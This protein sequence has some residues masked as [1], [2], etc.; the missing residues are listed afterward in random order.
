MSK[1]FSRWEREFCRELGESIRANDW[2]PRDALSETQ[3]D[4]YLAKWIVPHP[5]RSA[6]TPCGTMICPE[7]ANSVF[8]DMAR[9]LTESIEREHN[10]AA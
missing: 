6:L 7:W 10:H 4:A 2:K 1:D 3:I 9:D 5:G 8:T